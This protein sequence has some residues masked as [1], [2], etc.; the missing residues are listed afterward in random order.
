MWFVDA[1]FGFAGI[2]FVIIKFACDDFAIVPDTPF[3]IAI[4]PGADC[5]PHDVTMAFVAAEFC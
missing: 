5:I 3:N 4:T 1:V 2:G